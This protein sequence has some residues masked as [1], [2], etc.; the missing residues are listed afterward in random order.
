LALGW[1][2][3]NNDEYISGILL[4]WTTLILIGY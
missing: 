2:T 1:I 4:I 3:M